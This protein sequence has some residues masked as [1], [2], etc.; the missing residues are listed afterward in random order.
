MSCVSRDKPFY[1]QLHGTIPV[2]D[3]SGH[4]LMTSQAFREMTQTVV[5]TNLGESPCFAVHG[6]LVWDGWSF[7]L[8]ESHVDECMSFL[9]IRSIDIEKSV[10]GCRRHVEGVSSAD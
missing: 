9:E 1:S 3:S 5:T 10:D 7:L 2:A 4:G 8:E 6:V